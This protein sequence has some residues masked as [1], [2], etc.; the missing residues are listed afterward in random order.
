MC[1]L[2]GITEVYTEGSGNNKYNNH[3]KHSLC[4]C[5]IHNHAA[6]N[7]TQYIDV[8]K[9]DIVFYIQLHVSHR[10]WWDCEET[11]QQQSHQSIMFQP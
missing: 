2:C 8:V 10:S 4:I 11:R 5:V 6:M 1:V 7:T 9:T 3:F